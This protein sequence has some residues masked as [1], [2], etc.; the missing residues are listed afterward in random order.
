MFPRSPSPQGTR[1]A[2][3]S[4]SSRTSAGTRQVP[5]Q[6]RSWMFASTAKAQEEPLQFRAPH[7]ELRGMLHHAAGRQRGAVVLCTADGEERAWCHRT[8]MFLA[9]TLAERGFAVL[10]FEY[11][12]QGESGGAY[13][14]TTIATRAG[15]IAAAVKVATDRTGE[16][17]P[18]L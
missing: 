16:H 5:Q 15:D 3:S 8:Y 6:W 14:D 4:R 18:A 2:S 10:R 9:R 13:E 1:H 11:T 12:G 7:A 17:A